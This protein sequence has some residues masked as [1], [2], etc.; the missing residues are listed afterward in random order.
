MKTNGGDDKADAPRYLVATKARAEVQ[1]KLGETAQ[2]IELRH[3]GENS[4]LGNVAVNGSASLTQVLRW[5]YWWNLTE[6]SPDEVTSEQVLRELN[7]DFSTKGLT[8]QEIPSGSTTGAK[9]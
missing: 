1:R 8:A 3:S 9:A 2:S 6:A 7:T 4:I 5:A